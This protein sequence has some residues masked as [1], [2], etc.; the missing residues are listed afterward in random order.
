MNAKTSVFVI[1]VEAIIYLLL[2]NLHKCTFKGYVF[3]L[4]LF[5]TT[6]FLK[7]FFKRP[8]MGSKLKLEIKFK[9]I[10]ISTWQFADYL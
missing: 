8:F 9:K 5:I 7:Q 3:Y 4:N 1:C 10:T 2:Y 6:V